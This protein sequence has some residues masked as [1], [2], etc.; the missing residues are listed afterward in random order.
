LNSA[1][2]SPQTKA[3]RAL[4]EVLLTGRVLANEATL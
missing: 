1:P 2:Q 3:V 4:G